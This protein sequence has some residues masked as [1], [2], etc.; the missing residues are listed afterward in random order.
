M[1]DQMDEWIGYWIKR[2]YRDM[3]NLHDQ[4]LAKHSLTTSQVGVL[5]QLWQKDGLTQ[6]EI[7]QKLGIRPAS[8]T[9]LVDGLVEKGWVV[10]KSDHDDARV[11]RL[12][13]T[14]E[15]KVLEEVC[16]SIVK[17]MEELLTKGFT[18]E[19]LSLLCSWIKR[20]HRNVV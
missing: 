14:E 20:M 7:Q 17:E 16:L 10:R 13:L 18:P 4:K 5:A 9:G 12:F 8:L 19:E 11:K 2:T 1:N 15:G 3:T 6:K